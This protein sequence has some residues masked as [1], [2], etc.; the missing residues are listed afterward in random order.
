MIALPSIETIQSST[1]QEQ[2]FEDLQWMVTK[3]LNF[4][5]IENKTVFWSGTNRPYAIDWAVT[6]GMKTLEMT[7]GGKFLDR[8]D[9][10]NYKDTYTKNP[11]QEGQ[12]TQIWDLASTQFA[13]Q[14]R[15]KVYCFTIG[16][17]AWNEQ[18]KSVRTWFRV[19]LPLL[20]DSKEIDQICWMR[21]NGNCAGIYVTI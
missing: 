2:L 20:L 17:P 14:A 18:L 1:D 16:I 8:L 3:L 4:K 7:D 10:F 13:K 21:N 9:L 12:P 11:L 6:Q 19:E 5:T 15:G